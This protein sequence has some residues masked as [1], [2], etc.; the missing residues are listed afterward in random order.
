MLQKNDKCS[1]PCH[2]S[3]V[4]ENQNGVTDLLLDKTASFISFS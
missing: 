1:L 3:H 4:Y 2:F